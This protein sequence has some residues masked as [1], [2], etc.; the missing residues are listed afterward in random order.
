MSNKIGWVWMLVSLIFSSNLFADIECPVT[1]VRHVQVQNAVILVFPEGQQ[2]HKVG[3][4]GA[5]GV[6]QMYS[7]LLA[8]QMAG[9]KVA[10]RYPDGYDCSLYDLAIS[11]T[12]VRTYND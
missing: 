1:T 4:V 5:P 9:K 12:M 2:W 3:N 10:L 6:D 8:A 11:A 7:A